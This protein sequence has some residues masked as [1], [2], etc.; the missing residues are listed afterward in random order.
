MEAAVCMCSSFKIG[1]LKILAIF[2]EKRK[3]WSL[4]INKAAALNFC[5]FIKNRLQDK[6]FPQNIT[7]FL[8]LAFFTENIKPN[9]YQI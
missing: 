3:C 6:R 1:V 2:T 5:N 9:I 7:T 8:R 4:F